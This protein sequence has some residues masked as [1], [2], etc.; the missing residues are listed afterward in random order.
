M[1]NQKDLSLW[2]M[3]NEHQKLLSELYDQETGEVNEIVHAKLE[4]LYPD[5]EK[6]CVSVGK[7][8][9]HLESEMMQL[10]VLLEQVQIRRISYMQEIDRYKKY[11]E[12][13]MVKQGIKK[14]SCPYFTINLGKNPYSTEIISEDLVPEKFMKEKEIVKVEIK[15]DKNAIKEEFLRT[16]KQVDGTFVSQKNKLEISTRKI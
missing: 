14:I 1:N 12:I 2:Q 7:Y 8:I 15:P 13:N 9:N 11:L 16:G 3:T 10:D 5:I 6:K 4:S